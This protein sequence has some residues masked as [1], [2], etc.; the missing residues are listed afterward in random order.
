MTYWAL[1]N[2]EDD[3]PQDW[4]NECGC[5]IPRPDDTDMV[6]LCDE[7]RQNPPDIG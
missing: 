4:C 7:C 5:Q 2:L 6:P 1:D 3:A